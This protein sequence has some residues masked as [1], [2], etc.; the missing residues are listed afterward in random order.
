M[1]E[2]LRFK[3]GFVAWKN[4]F[5]PGGPPVLGRFFG[6]D[7]RKMAP[8]GALLVSKCALFF[9]GLSASMF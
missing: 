4:G 7:R 1:V 8:T 5:V 3:G 2:H 9:E 6:T